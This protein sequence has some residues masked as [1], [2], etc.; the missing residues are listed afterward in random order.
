MRVRLLCAFIITASLP[1]SRGAD[2]PAAD[3]QKPETYLMIPEP[4][5]MRSSI[6]KEHAGAQRTV[7]TPA[8]QGT[9]PR[10]LKTYTA[11]EFA[12]LGI[13]WETFLERAQVA[14]DR[15]LARMKPELIKGGNGQVAYAVYR[16]ADPGIA[17]LLIAPSLGKVFSNIFGDA[18]WL[19]TPDR[20]SLYVFP[21]KT[22]AIADFAADLSAR[23][24]GAAYAASAEIF[25]VKADGS[26]LR[27]VGC[28][29]LYPIRDEIPVMLIDEATI[30]E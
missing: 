29:R 3:V 14:A 6:S 19:V 15:K 18:V 22:E 1:S 4:K 27:C 24:K 10:S 11:A 13:S 21:A 20:N 8:K 28:H 23:F 30:D 17:C 12:K 2:A 5:V 16:G 7:F 26:G 9:E 25:E